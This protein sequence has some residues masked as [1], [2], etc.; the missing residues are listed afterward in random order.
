MEHKEKL[1]LHTP[2][3]VRKQQKTQLDAWILQIPLKAPDK[4]SLAV[5]Q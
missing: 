1:D 2:A 3:V 4:G 5:Q